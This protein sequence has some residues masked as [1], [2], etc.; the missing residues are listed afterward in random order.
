MAARRANIK[1][2]ES[3]SDVDKKVLQA[4]YTHR[5]LTEDLLYRFFYKKINISRDFTAR[6][7]RWMIQRKLVEPVEYG[8][9]LPALFLTTQGIETYRYIEDIPVE[10][11]DPETGMMKRALKTASDLKM[12]PNNIRHQIALNTFHLEF[13]ERSKQEFFY[14]YEDEKFIKVSA[15]IRPDGL[16]QM[17]NA[18]LFLEMDMG[19]ERRDDLLSKWNH[20][21][22]FLKSKNYRYKEKKTI[23]L[24][25]VNNVKLVEQ[26]R[27][28]ILSTLQV[29]LLD[30]LDSMFEVYVDTAENLLN[31]VF[32]KFTPNSFQQIEEIKNL[33][34][35]V[36]SLHQ[37]VSSAS[38]FMTKVVPYSDYMAYIRK[39]DHTRHILVQDG[40]PQEFLLDSYLDRPLT[41][42]HQIVDH[43]KVCA[44]M[45][46]SLGRK[47]PYLV[48]VSDEKS[49]YQDL[50]LAQCLDWSDVYFTT[51]DRLVSTSFP[52]AVFQ[53]DNNGNLFHFRDFGL[54]ERIFERTVKTSTSVKAGI[55]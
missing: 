4:I 24:F 19:T 17:N 2:I 27:A 46:R 39:L 20:Y 38:T 18:D 25:I 53:Y 51:K 54:Q 12:K 26:R 23:M 37:F 3:M 6:R 43:R 22:E 55:H 49:F 5:C 11:L 50:M 48:L 28:V 32:R 7:V 34:N 42:L 52:E 9:D 16:I 14:T 45:I 10:V 35:T 44:E 21:R 13:D 8:V 15:A 29:G 41:V 31:I 33:S 1:T 36:L 40:R 30:A 47:I